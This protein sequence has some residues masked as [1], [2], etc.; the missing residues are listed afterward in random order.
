MLPLPSKVAL[1]IW[2]GVSKNRTRRYETA[3][4]LAM[5]VHTVTKAGLAEDPSFPLNLSE[6]LCRPEGHPELL[7]KLLGEV[8]ASRP[9]LESSHRLEIGFGINQLCNRQAGSR[10]FILARI[11]WN[12]AL[13]L[14]FQPVKDGSS[15]DRIGE[16]IIAV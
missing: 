7:N 12:V 16:K 5:N 4:G 3:N 9:T 11:L 8:S 14:L 10:K 2:G 1:K 15:G 13:F 6:Q